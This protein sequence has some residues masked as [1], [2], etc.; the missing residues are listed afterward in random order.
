MLTADALQQSGPTGLVHRG[1]TGPVIDGCRGDV[2]TFLKLHVC[3]V[4]LS[5][6]GKRDQCGR[7]VREIQPRRI[8]PHPKCCED[9][10]ARYHD[11][12]NQN[13]YQSEPP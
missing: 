12:L 1:L 13:R 5:H 8:Q 10:D 11:E 6:A 7:I 4:F 2:W 9:E 3:F